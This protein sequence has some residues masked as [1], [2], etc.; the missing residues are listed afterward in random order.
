MKKYYSYS[1]VVIL[2][3]LSSC[4]S[5]KLPESYKVTPE[6]LEAKG[7]KVAFKVDGTVPEKSFHKKAVV[8]F[9]PYLKYG[10][11]T[12][13]LKPFVLRGEK[14]EG[15]GTVINSKTGGSFTYNEEFD[16]TNEMK[17]S[18]LFVNA[19]ITKGKSVKNVNDI[20]LADGIIAT[21][22]DISH[23][24]ELMF[25]PSGYE[26]VTVFGE[27]STIYFR[28]NI[29]K[30]EK[31]LALNKSTDAI[32]KMQ[33]LDDLLMKGWEIKDIA[34][35][36]WAS[37]EGEINFNN[38]LADDRAATG[39]KYMEQKIDKMYK[40]KAKKMG[41][42]VSDIEKEATYLSKGH[43]EDWDGF[44]KAVSSSDIKDKNQIMNV[45]N[46]QSDANMREQEIRNMTV[47]YKEIEDNI[48]PPLRRAEIKLSCFEPK[49]T[50]ENIAKLATSSPDSL[51]YKEILHAATLTNDPQ[52][53]YAIYKA[54]FTNADRDWKAY[55]NAGA[56][57]LVLGKNDEADNLLTQAAK[58]DAKNGKIENNMGVS[59]LRKGDVEGAEKHFVAAQSYGENENYNLGIINIMKGDYSK[60]LNFFKGASCT[61]NVGL[62][63]MLGGDMNNALKNL[64]C[65]PET[66]MTNYLIAVYGARTKN[67]DMV[68]EYLGK[69]VKM[70]GSLKQKA[71]QDR[72]FL[73]YFN[74]EAFKSLIK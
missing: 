42:K 67:A 10:N 36:A 65:A 73:K 32:A 64:K 21:Y 61:Q 4:M 8:E 24:E 66:A 56:E 72:E 41:K 22:N 29:S 3:Y 6:V 9:S 57:A 2:F 46:S 15:E 33:K 54:A 35:D 19:K 39:Q 34:I 62:A 63:Q 58:L 37:P 59:S 16:Y 55:N 11:Q 74:E 27:N 68:Y 69:A 18:E 7:G 51:S 50:D 70:D 26:K 53:K 14:T 40:D 5:T 44:L 71:S 23:D 28:V 38:H 13:N 30:Y 47:I 60:A 1:L 48:L 52:I 45:I 25:A 43:G 12:K 20:K 49:R 31:D 17:V